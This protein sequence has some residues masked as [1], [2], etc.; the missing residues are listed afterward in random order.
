MTSVYIGNDK[1]RT[2][3]KIRATFLSLSK[4]K[5]VTSAGLKQLRHSRR[6]L[7]YSLLERENLFMRVIWVLTVS[8][9]EG[10]LLR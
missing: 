8:V 9:P 3:Q 6:P 1:Y 10:F 4:E 7:A 5:K 2:L